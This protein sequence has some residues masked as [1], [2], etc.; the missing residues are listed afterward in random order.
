M[1]FQRITVQMLGSFA[2]RQGDREIGDHSN[3]MRKVWLLLAYLIY[4]RNTP[5]TQ[6]HYLSLLGGK[7]DAADEQG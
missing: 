4:H 7:D 3:R 1:D 2:V 6:E 5:V